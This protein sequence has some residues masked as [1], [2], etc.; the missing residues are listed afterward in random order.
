MWSPNL[1]RINKF[2][3]ISEMRQMPERQHAI[4]ELALKRIR[5]PKCTGRVLETMMPDVVCEKCGSQ[6]VLATRVGGGFLSGGLHA[7]LIEKNQPQQVAVQMA[8]PQASI[9]QAIGG[10]FCHHCGSSMSESAKF[11]NKCGTQL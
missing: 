1:Q 9:P 8:R 3:I 6:F 7:Q 5:C 2:R 11:C 4:F 10:K